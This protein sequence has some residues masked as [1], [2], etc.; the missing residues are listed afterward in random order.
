MLRFFLFCTL[1]SIG[2]A[3]TAQ[4]QLSQ[5]RIEKLYRRGTDLVNHS[6]YGAARQVF[7]EFLKAS[8]PTD[9]R[10]GEAEYYIGFSALT[11][12]HSDGE[13]LIDDFIDDYPSSP[14][15][16][17]AYY[18][19]ALFFYAESSYIKAS[20]YF[21]KVEFPALTSDQ[22][23]QGHFKWGYS[24]FN[25]KK[26]PEA[27]EQFNFV[28]KQSNSYSPAANY[29]AGFVEYSQGNYDEALTD[30]KKA[31][32]SSAY[33]SIVPYL[34]TNVYYKQGKYD[35]MLLYTNSLKGK[36][37]LTN[38][39]EISMLVAEAQFY[40]GDYLKALDSYQKYLDKGT[41]VETGL[42]FRAGYANYAAGNIEKGIE[43]LER[44]SA[45]K[46]TVSYYASYYLGILYIKQGNKPY[47]L[48]SFNYAK[49]NPKD[50]KLAEESSFQFAKISYDAGKP[51]Q[52]IDEFERFLKTYPT[53]PHANEVNELL[54]Q[55]Y[56]NGNNF[57]KA[58]QYIEALP[59]RNQ[60]ID[61]SYQK[62]AFLKGSDL[63]NKNEYQEAVQYFNRSLDY[64]NDKNYVALASLWNG[65]AY[66]VGKFY[67]DA[68]KNYV[69]VVN[70]GAGVDP[71]VILKTRYGLGYAYFNL[72][73][74]EKALFSFKE[75]V[76]KASKTTPNYVDGL[77]RLA[78]CYYIRKQYDDALAN[79]NKARTIGGP[80]NDYVL[81][82]S[83]V[84]YGIQNKYSESRNLFADL[85]RA[86]PKSQYKDEALY[87][88][89]QSEI[90]QG[91]YQG[92]VDALSTLI[93][94]SSSAKY[95]PDALNRRAAS[96]LN[97]K[98]YDKTIADY[99]AII[100]QY[101]TH[102]IANEII[103]PLQEAYSLAGRSADFE[104]QLELIK[105]ANPGNKAL[106]SVEFETAKNVYF[107]Q[108]YQ[109]A[110]TSL[111]AF[112][113]SYP[114]SAKIP[115]AKYY[116]AE[117]NYRLKNFDKALPV[118]KELASD[119][120]LSFAGKSVSRVAEIEFKQSNYQNA[121]TSYRSFGKMA[122]NKK[123]QYTAWSGSMESFFQLAQYDSSDFYARLILRQGSVNAGAQNKA[124]LFLG[125][126]A[127][128]KGD[129]DTAKDEFLNTLNAARDEYGAEA[130]YLL[131]KI[132]SQQKDYKQSNEVLIG[133]SADF[134]SYEAW[135]GKAFLLL[136]DNFV[137]TGEIFQAKSTLQSLIDKFPEQGVKD[138]A[139][140]KLE[141]IDKAEA[142]KQK[143]VEADT[144][145]VNR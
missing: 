68:I 99:T 9:A 43:Y 97:L 19:L 133:L 57:N 118:Y 103:V 138:E 91:N 121:V 64:P 51:D 127:M 114:Q 46:D 18:D 44:A 84:I 60:Y 66:S 20:S 89:A 65:E 94:T 105:K 2:H 125:K 26:L 137:A 28:K 56:V 40:K 120:S 145:E 15:A 135:V 47:A 50:K 112:V 14:K 96:Y 116:I 21:K 139:R 52:A 35:A 109:R 119:M 73:D 8:S 144:T 55:A 67:D 129:L 33:S 29:Y 75:F 83:A 72:K 13:K 30:L 142:E 98:Q 123:D 16:A 23:S 126:S 38:A 6:N 102:P 106:E 58:I 10:R 107:D 1:F 45:A 115:E 53:S 22:Q 12:G 140:R 80:D 74:Y 130:K 69:R 90:E 42:L 78:D 122:A 143:E 41:K 87:Q 128:A 77:I 48:N 37:D 110:V 7:S 24:Y 131:G 61:Q 59:S 136:A 4:D 71:E 36:T 132:L 34:I 3:T 27:L 88:Q 31:E 93:S 141:V 62:A 108:Q 113:S 86:Y 79:Y 100:Q 85:A 70:L 11:L 92:A 39:N 81:L 63:F 82:Q 111:G 95:V 101:P 54:A 104:K 25:Q 76:N 117:S 17:T 32:T 124:S 49:N 134:S 5:N